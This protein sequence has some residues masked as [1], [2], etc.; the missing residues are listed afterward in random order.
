MSFVSASEVAGGSLGE[1]PRFDRSVDS[2]GYLWWYVDG[3]SEDGRLGF[4]V[5]AFIGSV[6]SPY[7]RWARRGLA[8]PAAFSSMHVVLYGAGHKRW[9]MID[10]PRSALLRSKDLLQIGKS[11]LQWTGSE[12]TMA[13]DERCFP[14]PQ[15][16][17]GT[18]K[19]HTD[20][21]GSTAAYLDANQNHRWWP[22][23]PSAKVE[24]ALEEPRIRWRGEGYFDSNDGSVPLE[25][26]F[27]SWNWSR[28]SRS[29]GGAGILYDVIE[30]DGCS[31]QISLLYEPKLGTKV[32]EGPS[33]TNELA[34]TRW[35]LRRTTRAEDGSSRVL[36]T[37]LDSPF[38][39]RSVIRS[40]LFD[41]D[42][43][44]M[45]ESLDLTRFTNPVV[46]LMLPFRVG[47]VRTG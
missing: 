46:Q 24:V 4:T 5:I 25:D 15:R 17:R 32:W 12:L 42:I 29:D 1:G 13:L 14:L 6:F 41:Q 8:D 10:R 40:R 37:L 3:L 7:Y 34:K 43:T 2:N 16:I 19:V 39:S 38:Y 20:V 18:I 45:H 11:T 28:G 26:S 22:I 30:R 21:V 27:T 31:R 35:R 9:S 36:R 47:R 44:A 33:V 23:N